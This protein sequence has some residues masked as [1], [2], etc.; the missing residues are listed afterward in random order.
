[1]GDIRGSAFSHYRR[2]VSIW[3]VWRAWASQRRQLARLDERMLRDIGVS[4]AAAEREAR[5]PFW[6]P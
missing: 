3:S 2:L 5:K 1:M 4:R 6:R